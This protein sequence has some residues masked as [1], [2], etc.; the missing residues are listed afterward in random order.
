M[1]DEDADTPAPKPVR[2][3]KP[4]PGDVVWT[5]EQTSRGRLISVTKYDTAGGTTFENVVGPKDTPDSVKQ[6]LAARAGVSV[7]GDE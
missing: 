1:A 7:P 6:R 2:A 4:Q 3:K 5:D